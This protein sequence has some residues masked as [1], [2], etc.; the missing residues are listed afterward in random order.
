M[1]EKD[2]YGILDF[3]NRYKDD[4][5]KWFTAEDILQNTTLSFGIGELKHHLSNFLKRD[6]WIQFEESKNPALYRISKAGQNKFLRLKDKEI[7]LQ[8]ENDFKDQLKI[9][10]QSTIDTGESVQKVNNWQWVWF[11]AT[12]IVAI[13]GATA[14]WTT[15]FNGNAKSVLLQQ[16]RVKD[17]LLQQKQ[18]QQ[19]HT[20][21]R[22]D[23]LIM[24]ERY[25]SIKKA[26]IVP[27]PSKPK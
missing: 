13:I 5:D 20:E 2:I 10:N 18:I 19:L 8:K 24:K 25:D 27:S 21:K 26:Y 14:Q 23:S 11:L 6:S 4:N 22:I 15:Y 3:L 12:L 7:S 9:V 1:D 17:S 16:L